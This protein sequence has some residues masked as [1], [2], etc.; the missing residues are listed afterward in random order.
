LGAISTK[1]RD[2]RMWS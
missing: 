2:R 1:M